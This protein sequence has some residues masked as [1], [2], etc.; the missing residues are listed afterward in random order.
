MAQLAFLGLGQMGARMASRL[1]DAG[2]D[3]AVWNRTE[4]RTDDLVQRGA[5]RATSPADAAAAAD[6]V[7]TMLADPE[8]LEA[9]V[10]GHD[11]IAAGLGADSTL[12][13][14]STVGPDVARGVG[15]RLGG[16]GRMI[17]APVLGSTPR[18]QDGSL[19]IFVGGTRDLYDRWS[20][21][22]S[23]LGQPR[24]VGPLGAGASMKLVTNSVLGAL[25]TALAEALSLADHLGLDEPVVLDVLAKSPIGV[26]VESKRDKIESRTYPPN[27]RLSLAAKDV[28]LVRAAAE[29]ARFDAGVAAAAVAAFGAA[30]AAGLGDLD[31]SAVVAHLRGQTAKG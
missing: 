9:V 18:A 31:Y 19:D 5:R 30:E 10:F 24:H 13:D 16:D 28:G 20:P 27:F 4:G 6:G 22:L 12:I 26:T 14:M 17:D 1:L 8:A 11:G 23:V 25:M 15:A 2:H 29:R 7:F 21:V 3:V